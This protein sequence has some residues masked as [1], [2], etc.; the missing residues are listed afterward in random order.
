V[1]EQPEYQ[2]IFTELAERLKEFQSKT[3]DPWFTKYTYE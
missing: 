2:R 3:R 1:A